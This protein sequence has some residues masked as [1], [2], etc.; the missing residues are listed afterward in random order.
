MRQTERVPPC[1]FKDL[2]VRTSRHRIQEYTGGHAMQPC[3]IVLQDSCLAMMFLHFRTT[4]NGEV[5]CDA[6]KVLLSYQF[7]KHVVGQGFRQARQHPPHTGYYR[8][9]SAS[10][11][12]KSSRLYTYIVCAFTPVWPSGNKHVARRVDISL[13]A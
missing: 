9:P 11:G 1:A 10:V 5:W 7:W 12:P 4:V 8:Q 6:S 2:D 13:T 3:C